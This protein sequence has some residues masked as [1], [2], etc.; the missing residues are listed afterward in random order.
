MAWC[1]QWSSAL[2]SPL[3]RLAPQRLLGPQYPGEKTKLQAWGLQSSGS[4]SFRLAS[5]HHPR[6]L[7]G[8][9]DTVGMGSSPMKH[10]KLLSTPLVMGMLCDFDDFIFIQAQLIFSSS[11]LSSFLVLAAVVVNVVISSIISPESEEACIRVM[12]LPTHHPFRKPGWWR[13]SPL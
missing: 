4:L 1:S 12:P 10:V 6:L 9:S 3:L 2:G 13:P 7:T 11:F 5:Y 8:C